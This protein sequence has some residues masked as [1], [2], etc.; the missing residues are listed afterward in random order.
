MAFRPEQCRVSNRA[1]GLTRVVLDVSQV[2]IPRNRVA[3]GGPG[4]KGVPGVL[5]IHVCAVVQHGISQ[6]LG[7]DGR[8]QSLV[9]GL[10]RRG[11]SKRATG[12]HAES[13]DASGVDVE[14]GRMRLQ[15]GNTGVDVVQG[16]RIWMLW[17]QAVVRRKD[18]GRS[19][20]GKVCN[21]VER[22][23]DTASN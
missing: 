22:D 9:S 20:L 15:L 5:R 1:I 17:R 11:G 4:Q 21:H 12:A 13:D 19:L 8:A 14:L 16:S 2:R 7:S 18:L 10:E 6:D 3:T 23:G